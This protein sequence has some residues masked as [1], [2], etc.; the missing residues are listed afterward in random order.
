MDKMKDYYNVLGVTE[1]ASVEEIKEAFHKKAKECHPDRVL[2]PE[3]KEVRK[4]Q[5]Q[6]LNEAYQILSSSLERE[7][8]DQ[9]RETGNVRYQRPTSGTTPEDISATFRMIVPLLQR[10]LNAPA[11]LVEEEMNKQ[12][13]ADKGNEATKC[14]RL[15]LFSLGSVCRGEFTRAKQILA[16]AY[17]NS[18]TEFILLAKE[19]KAYPALKELSFLF[20]QA[21]EYAGTATDISPIERAS[22]RKERRSALDSGYFLGFIVCLIVMVISG[23]L[24]YLQR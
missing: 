6:E 9:K 14:S 24:A 16:A 8:Y 13:W 12:I 15:I 17:S 10:A 7:K 2:S 4:R 19:M 18:S 21:I 3:E 22:T 1:A 11:D 20:E 5:F 23:L